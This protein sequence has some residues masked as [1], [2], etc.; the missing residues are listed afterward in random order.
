MDTHEVAAEQEDARLG[1][2]R[3]LVGDLN[4]EK[5]V[6]SCKVKFLHFK[7]ILRESQLT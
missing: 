4:E 7:T 1:D 5:W 2:P 3:H 6:E